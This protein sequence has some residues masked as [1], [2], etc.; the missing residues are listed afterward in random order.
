MINKTN[1]KMAVIISIYTII[2]SNSETLKLAPLCQAGG[3]FHKEE[4][5]RRF[6]Y[7]S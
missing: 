1:K 5:D 6:S 2:W 3:L 4:T 7:T